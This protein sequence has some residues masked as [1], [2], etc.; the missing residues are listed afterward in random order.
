[1][2]NVIK[3][4]S[5]RYDD[6]AKKT[7]GSHFQISKESEVK[8]I[9]APVEEKPQE[10]FVEGLKAVVVEAL[11]S[12]EETKEEAA[13]VTEKAK[14][15]AKAILD[16]AKQEAEQLK[17]DAQEAAR[18]KG[19]E[20]GMQQSK[21]EAQRL[22]AE[23][24]EKTGKLQKEYESRTLSLEPQMA[25][26]IAE[27]VERMTG[28]L[29]KDREEVILYLIN[30]AIKNMDR[31]SEYT[32]K[33]S[34]EDFE[35]VSEKRNLLEGAIGSDAAIYI[36]EDAGLTKNQCLIETDLKVIN[37][38]LDIQLNNLISD[39]KLINSI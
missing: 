18:K 26:I 35:Y 4:Y 1:M 12:A 11:P 29:V 13:K 22:K 34:K 17:K 21:R 5:V 9:I 38:S 16:Q 10:G 19:Y 31:S 25:Q 7:I 14:Q 15:E 32:I 23:Y 36:A 37:C 30:R 8:R 28:I 2:S 6:E 39:L 3:A 24:E 33:V 27:L 20:E